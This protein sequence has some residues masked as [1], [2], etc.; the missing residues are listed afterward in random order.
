MKLT[1][2]EAKATQKFLG[3]SY[4]K[5]IKVAKKI[6]GKTVNE[7]IQILQFAPQA[8]ARATLKVLRSAVANA[9][10]TKGMNAEALVVKTVLVNKA[11]GFK[12]INYRARGRADRMTRQNNHTTVVVAERV[13]AAA[14]A[15]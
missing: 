15:E 4:K 11:P 14:K 10:E 8:A 3:Y 7:A 9:V 5:G 1:Q 13:S 6:R 12:R 2:T